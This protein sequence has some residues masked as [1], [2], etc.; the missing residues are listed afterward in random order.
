[1]AIVP[2][3]RYPA[4][5]D[6]T[7]PAYPHGKAR[8]ATSPNDGTGF[9][10]ERDWVNDWLGFQQAVLDEA[11]I[12]PS[13]SPDEV[14]ASDVLDGMDVLYYRRTVVDSAIADE[15]SARIAADATKVTAGYAVYTV[16]S[17]GNY[18]VGAPMAL[19]E[20][21]VSDGFT[22]TSGNTVEV[23]SAGVYLVSISIHVSAA[24]TNA[25][26]A[27]AAAG[28]SRFLRADNNVTAGTPTGLSATAAVVITDPPNQKIQLEAQ[29]GSGTMNVTAAWDS[30]LSIVRISP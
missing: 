3:D 19:T 5:T 7:D 13:G 22:L 9:P 26:G 8:N 11:E 15:A 24:S 1:M 18:A 30:K 14:G 21:N 28:G 23:P 6:D 29:H 2:K 20:L 12:E 10:L 17:F 16:N 4:Q 27:H 25:I